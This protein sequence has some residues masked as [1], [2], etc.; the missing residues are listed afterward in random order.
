MIALPNSWKVYFSTGR[1][2]EIVTTV[3]NSEK[4]A[5]FCNRTSANIPTLSL[6]LLLHFCS[7]DKDKP[8]PR[9][10]KSSS[11]YRVDFKSRW[12]YSWLSL[13]HRT[14]NRTEVNTTNPRLLLCDPVCTICMR[15]KC[16]QFIMQNKSLLSFPAATFLWILRV[17]FQGVNKLKSTFR[18]FR[19]LSIACNKFPGKNNM[20]RFW[21]GR[22]SRRQRWIEMELG[23]AVRL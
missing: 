23:M 16:H 10:C 9:F 14:V 5:V 19:L 7:A 15:L 3:L 11:W 21:K 2:G 17:F 22:Q 18:E 1:W 13:F 8:C 20:H 4:T 12:I 6:P